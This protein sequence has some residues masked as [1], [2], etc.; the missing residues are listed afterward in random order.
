[1]KK[2]LYLFAFTAFIA[3]MVS[4]DKYEIPEP[5]ESIPY[6]GETGD[7]VDI[8]G[9]EDTIPPTG[10]E[11]IL[12]PF[13]ADADV[14]FV[15]FQMAFIADP[16]ADSL[17]RIPMLDSIYDRWAIYNAGFIDGYFASIVGAEVPADSLIPTFLPDEVWDTL[18]TIYPALFSGF[19]SDIQIDL[20]DPGEAEE[21]FNER[22]NV[23]IDI[24]MNR[25][26]DEWVDKYFGRYANPRKIHW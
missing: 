11:D 2:T 24:V 12:A 18:V 13:K 7:T 25:R 21:I 23:I 20:L 6:Q 5:I 15:D 22:C 3:F 14:F 4:C 26:C 19:L 10:E 8:P 1:M 17:L 9:G 16:T